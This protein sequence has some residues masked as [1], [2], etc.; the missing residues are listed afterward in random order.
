MVPEEWTVCTGYSFLGFF[1]SVPMVHHFG[2]LRM[3][4]VLALQFIASSYEIAGSSLRGMGKSLTPALLTVFG[5][6]L[7]RMV[8]VYVVSPI[9]RGYD[10]L[11][12]VYPV[13]WVV[14]GLLVLA[15]YWMTIR[16]KVAKA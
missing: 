9:W 5:T 10:V 6:C 16:K 15:A 1:S 4:L 2:T 7:L 8:W 3:H 12:I 11:M 13:S 14:T